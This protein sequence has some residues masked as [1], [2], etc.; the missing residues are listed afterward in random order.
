[1]FLFVIVDTWRQAYPHASAGVL[2]IRDVENPDTHALLENR[3]QSLEGELRFQYAGMDRTALASLPTLQAYN[4]YY[5]PYKKSYHVQLQLES[6]VMKGRSIPRVSALVTAMFMAELKN[7]LLTAGHDLAKVD[8]PVRLEAARGDEIYTTMQG[9]EKTLKAGDM[10]M[11]DHQGVISSVL[12]GPDART[13]IT[14]HTRAVVFTIYAPKGIP[15]DLVRR[16]LD[17]ISD[18]VILVSPGAHVEMREVYT[19]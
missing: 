17:E 12:Y 3:I 7:L 5:K 1:M 13:R 4:A 9:A 11:A 18:H 8:G 2:V 6:L 15:V 10:F 16:H 14:S 19:P